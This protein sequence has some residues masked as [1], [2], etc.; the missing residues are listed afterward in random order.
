MVGLGTR[1]SFEKFSLLNCVIFFS[2]LSTFSCQIPAQGKWQKI[3]ANS[4]VGKVY[5]RM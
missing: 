1:G 4:M 5:M 2:F 3:Y